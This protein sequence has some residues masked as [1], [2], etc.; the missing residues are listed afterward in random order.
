MEPPRIISLIASATEIVCALGFRDALVGRSHECDY[1]P[2]VEHLP[3][4]SESRVNVAASSREIDRQVKAAVADA[5]SVYRVKTEELQ[6]LK[7]THVITQTQCEVCAVSLKDVEL[8]IC[9]LVD[10]RPQIV[11]LEPMALADVWRDIQ[12]VADSL[13]VPERGHRLI[14][15]LQSRLHAVAASV[16]DRPERPSVVC[17]EWIDPLMSGGNW[18]PELVEIAG[19]RPLLAQAGL[20]S[21]WMT[22]DDLAAADPDL[23][24]I[25]PCGFDIPRTLA[26]LPPLLQN[27]RWH[28]LRAVESGRVY[29]TD[30][31]QYFN[32]P[33]P[34]VVESAEILADVIH[35]PHAARRHYRTGWIELAEARHD[36]AR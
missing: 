10:S 8:A 31:N 27:P 35:R 25:L 5:L 3:I 24:V 23:I 34:R 36:A 18:M 11:T 33:G 30:G 12:A 4:C 32:R 16:A 21:P 20:H 15:D 26:E 1:P 6:R 13:G 14:A 29:V 2:D 22:W 9:E 19:G 28:A 17:L 7:P